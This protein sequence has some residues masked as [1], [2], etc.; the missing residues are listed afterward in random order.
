M[1]T[2]DYL[3]DLLNC[4]DTL[5]IPAEL[6]KVLIGPREALYDFFQELQKWRGWRWDADSFQYLYEREMSERKGKKQD[7]TPIS[8]QGL[9]SQ[10]VDTKG[11]IHE[12]TAGNGGLIIAS[13]WNMAHKVFPWEF[14]PNRHPIDCWELSDRSIPFLLCN[15]AIRGIVGVVH[16][17][18]VLEGKEVHRYVLRN[19]S[20]CLNYSVIE[21]CF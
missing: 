13:W 12:P 5:D 9:L 10:L 17:G 21:K 14:D 8:V 7:F 6:L 4:K 16:H 3:L 11:S 18:D 15:L 1:E 19:S 20:D 2:T